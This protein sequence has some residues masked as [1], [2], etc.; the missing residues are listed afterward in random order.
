[1]ALVKRG[2]AV[3]DELRQGVGDIDFLADPTTGE[4]RI[5]AVEG[6]ASA[7]VAPLIQR[8]S[9]K[10][11]RM[12]FSV[13]VSGTVKLSND[14]SKRAIEVA[15]ART[16]GALP[17]DQ[18]GETL[19]EDSLVI[20]TAATNPLLR[21]RAITLAHLIDEPWTLEPPD[22]FFGGLAAMAFSGA[23]LKPPKA[24]IV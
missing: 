1:T 11:P 10:Y 19:F 18:Q 3:F 23:G 5:G 21:K 17:E 12:T 15:I 2:T 9:A 13:E 14:L 22:T 8:L 7:V 4:L 24:T 6:I 20:V 16:T